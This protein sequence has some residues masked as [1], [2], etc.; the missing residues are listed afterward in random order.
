MVPGTVRGSGHHRLGL[1]CADQG[2][3]SCLVNYLDAEPYER[4]LLE[5]REVVLSAW[6]P[7]ALASATR[8]RLVPPATS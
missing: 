8:I 3:P 5:P 1:L 7:V 2:S 6:L 4:R